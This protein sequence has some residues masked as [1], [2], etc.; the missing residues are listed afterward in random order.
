MNPT[1]P[2]KIPCSPGD[3]IKL[4]YPACYAEVVSIDL[5]QNATN[6]NNDC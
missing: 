3:I 5:K 6:P 2:N 1:Y 4:T